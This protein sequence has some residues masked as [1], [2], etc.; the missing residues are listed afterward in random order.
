MG[1]FSVEAVRFRPAKI[2]DK[3]KSRRFSLE[4][5]GLCALED[6][7]TAVRLLPGAELSFAEEVRQWTMTTSVITYKTAIFRRVNND[8]SHFHHDALEFPNRE[9]VL[10]TT[11]TDEPEVTVLQLPAAPSK[12][13]DKARAYAWSTR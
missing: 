11:L 3:L 8:K 10:L 7:E 5:H 9:I 12:G 13:Q 4:T 2:G 6:H 1:D